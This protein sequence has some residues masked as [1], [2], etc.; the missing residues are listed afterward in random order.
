MLASL[1]VLSMATMAWWTKTVNTVFTVYFNFIQVAQLLWVLSVHEKLD[2]MYSYT[3]QFATINLITFN[4][5]FQLTKEIIEKSQSSNMQAFHYLEA[6]GFCVLSF[7]NVSFDS[8][9]MQALFIG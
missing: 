8:V 1:G 3:I 9:S 2:F 5:G 6:V 4:K 7:L